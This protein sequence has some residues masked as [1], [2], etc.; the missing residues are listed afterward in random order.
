[1]KHRF[2]TAANFEFVEAT[3]YYE[4]QREGLG[5]RFIGEVERGVDVIL[6]AWRRWPE[7]EPGVRR[8]RLN[9]FPYGLFYRLASED[10]IE[11]LAVA[12]LRRRPGYWKDRL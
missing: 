3:L 10:E 7:V 12:D 9:R 11:I 5:L 8:Y 1:M 2:T 6:E 4:R